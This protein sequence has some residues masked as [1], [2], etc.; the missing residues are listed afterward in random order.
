MERERRAEWT[1]V[2]S[3]PTKPMFFPPTDHRQKPVGPTTDYGLPGVFWTFRPSVSQLGRELL[4][5]WGN[6]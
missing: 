6:G 2:V 1:F 5:P 3:P 4:F